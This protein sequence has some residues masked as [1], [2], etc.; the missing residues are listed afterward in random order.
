MSIIY[1]GMDV[2]KDTYTLCSY[3]HVEDEVKYKQKV[4]SDLKNVLRYADKIKIQYGLDTHLI[5]GY[6]AGCVGYTLYRDLTNAGYDCVILAPTSMGVTNTNGVKTDKNDAENIAKCLAYNLYSPVSVPTAKDEEVKE[7]LR[8]RDDLKLSLKKL[9]QQVL[10]FI[11]RHG[12]RYNIEGRTKTYWTEAHLKW[13]N[14]LEFSGY[15]QEAF[16]EYMMQ[17][18]YMSSKIDRIEKRIEEI[19]FTDEYS[20]RVSKLSCLLG[21][22][23]YTA[24]NLIVEVGDFTRF[25]KPSQ[26]ASFLGLVPGEESSG[27]TV[28]RTSITKAGNSFL[29]RTLV[30]S[31]Q[32]YCRG[33][34]GHKSKELNRRQQGNPPEVILYADKCN[35]R[36]R[37][38]YYRMTLSNGKPRNVAATAVARELSCFIWGLM[39]DNII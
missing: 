23:T 30:E 11:L 18:N 38:K 4:K 28:R 20:E 7:F 22:R 17:Y 1:I 36:L 3:S 12:F 21:V 32:S 25:E 9:K 26:F 15:M 14:T 34:I 31:A 19:A 27:N 16:D 24:M 35:E 6:E 29:R 37:R 33:A 2:H 39:T 10:A 8:M 13:M 5:F